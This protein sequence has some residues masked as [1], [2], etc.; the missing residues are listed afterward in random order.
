MI[1]KK[2]LAN[3]YQVILSFDIQVYFISAWLTNET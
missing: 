1:F 2:T 3:Y